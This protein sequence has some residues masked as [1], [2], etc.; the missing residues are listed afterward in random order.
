MTNCKL[1]QQ[2]GIALLMAMLV[3]ALAS[4][5]AVTLMHEQSL[6]VRRS[7]HNRNSDQAMMYSL[8][9]E[10]YARSI[11]Q[12]D[13]KN[14]KTDH[15]G[16]DWALGVPVLPFDGGY[17]TGGIQDEQ[18]KI[19]LNDVLVQETEDRLRALCNTLAIRSEFIDALKDWVDDDLDTVSPDGAEDDYYT[20]LEQPYRTAN[21]PLSDVTELRL[22]KGVDAELYQALEPFVTALPGQTALNINT[23]SEQVYLTLGNN[24]D[25]KKFINER[26]KDPFSSLEDYKK[27]MN[28]TLP[29]NGVSVKTE[30]FLASGQVT[31]ADRTLYVKTLIHRDGKG[32]TT[33]ISRKLGA[34]S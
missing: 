26:E 29:K 11:L 27:R 16:E 8:G 17:L 23:V 3:V 21:G 6:S 1:R 33:L 34:F 15:L 7:E 28:H 30:Y 32:V 14:S 12:K 5:T 20:G 2:Q 4:V 22:V 31:F 19:N 10:D 25:A 24:L 13:F 18:A 9:L